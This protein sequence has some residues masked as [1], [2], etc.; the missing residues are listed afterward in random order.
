MPAAES[1]SVRPPITMRPRSGRTTPAMAFTIVDF[2]EPERPKRATIG[3][4]DA[5]AASTL[6]PPRRM[7]TS[8]SSMARAPAGEPFRERERQHREQDRE[9][10]HAQ[11]QRVAAGICV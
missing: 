1:K 8:T 11:R 2:P 10:R 3:A 9:D 4:P 5:N 6:K 7:A